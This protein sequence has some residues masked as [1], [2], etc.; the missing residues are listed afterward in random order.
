MLINDDAIKLQINKVLHNS[1]YQITHLYF[2][3]Y[4]ILYF[5]NILYLYDI[6]ENNDNFI[7]IQYNSFNTIK[8]KFDT[9]IYCRS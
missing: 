1:F 2:Y 8:T 7:K 4:L 3:K 5:I 9:V 6:L